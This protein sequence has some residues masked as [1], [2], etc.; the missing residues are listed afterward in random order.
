M[1]GYELARLIRAEARRRILLIALT[2]YGAPE[3]RRRSAESG[4]DL[5]L[6]KPLDGEELEQALRA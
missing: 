5:H 4:F 2:G 6:V 1:D 3:D